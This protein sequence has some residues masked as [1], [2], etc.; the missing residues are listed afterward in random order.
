MPRIAQFDDAKIFMS[1]FGLFSRQVDN[2]VGNPATTPM[3][4]EVEGRHSV[5]LQH[6]PVTI[7]FRESQINAAQ[8]QAG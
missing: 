4:I 2:R 5:N 8:P 1:P 3:I 7:I 6:D